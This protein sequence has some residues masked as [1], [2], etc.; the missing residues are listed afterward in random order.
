MSVGGRLSATGR[1][2]IRKRLVAEVGGY[3]RNVI[4]ASRT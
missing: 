1:S 2:T 3:L 4:S